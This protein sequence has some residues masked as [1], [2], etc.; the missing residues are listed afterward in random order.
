MTPL[1]PRRTVRR[2]PGRFGDRLSRLLGES[3][4]DGSRLRLTLVRPATEEISR[5]QI[6]E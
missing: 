6:G 5:E 4:R 2:S 1:A 3:F